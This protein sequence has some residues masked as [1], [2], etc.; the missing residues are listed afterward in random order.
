MSQLTINQVSHGIMFGNFSNEQ[1]DAVTQA[2]KYARSQ[3]ARDTKRALAI[4][5]TVKFTHP[6]TGRVHAGNVVKINIKKIKVQ[7]G[8]TTWAVPANMISVAE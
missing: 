5:D 3:L 8:L 2:V 6:K 1:L 7:E 4:G